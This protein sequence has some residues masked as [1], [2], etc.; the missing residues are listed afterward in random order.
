M[1]FKLFKK[2]EPIKP[3]EHNKQIEDI[4]IKYR[5][6]ENQYSAKDMFKI[7][8]HAVPKNKLDFKGYKHK[9]LSKYFPLQTIMVNMQLT[10]GFHMQFIVR[11]K[12]GGFVFDNGFY[13]VDDKLKYYN[14]STK[15]WCLNYHEELCFPVSQTINIT[16][17]KESLIENDDVELETAVNPIS[18]QKFMESTVIQKLLAGAEMEDSLRMIKII[19]ICSG[20]ISFVT[21][22]LVANMS[23]LLG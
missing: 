9:L 4:V 23:G 21:L 10:N 2:K 8:N 22:L 12:N 20:M 6:K 13:I 7:Y 17:I 14:A 11:I 3:L 19:V 1:K 5:E 16:D 15:M 18:L